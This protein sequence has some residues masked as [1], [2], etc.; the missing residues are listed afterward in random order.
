M[1]LDIGTTTG[2]G[3][4]SVTKISS[5]AQRLNFNCLWVGEDITQPYDVF[6]MVSTALL[7]TSKIKVGIGITS[8][9]IRNIS[10]IAR[11]SA[12]LAEIGHDNRFILGLGVGGLQD[13]ARLGLTVKSPSI[14]LRDAVFLLR[15]IWKGKTQTFKDEYF[16]LDR[17]SARYTAEY[18]IPIYLGVRGPRLL[19]LAGLIADG[20]LL[21]G[22]RTYLRKAF[23]L[24]KRGIR[25]SE[26]PYRTF[27]FVMWIPTILTEKRT[28]I[29][30]AKKIVTIV[31]SDA[32]SD[33]LEM[34]ELDTKRVDR[35]R[36]A[37]RSGGIEKAAHLVTDDLV[38]ETT[39][40]G[41]AT[42]ICEAFESFEDS[43]FNEAVFGPPYGKNRERAI[44]LLAETW[45]RRS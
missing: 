9:L 20:V 31:L 6:T 17:Y 12:T 13:L 32:S 22:P 15:E 10:T 26:E 39:I 16:H 5:L 40:Y 23:D 44:A 33:V 42:Q 36:L 25:N 41:K 1:L 30:L 38:R 43:G 18:D 45:R 21:S 7:K 11:A 19:E 35:I 34:A 27:H 24:V 8:P 29:N 4:N 37:L 3:I 28:D 2:A 14:L